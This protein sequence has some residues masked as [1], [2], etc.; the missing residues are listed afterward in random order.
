[1][2]RLLPNQFGSQ[3]SHIPLSEN[4]TSAAA[5]TTPLEFRNEAVFAGGDVIVIDFLYSSLFLHEK[6]EFYENQNVF[7]R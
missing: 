7:F 2:Y 1:M 4:I 3:T 6:Y 5:S